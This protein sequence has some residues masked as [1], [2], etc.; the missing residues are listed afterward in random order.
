MVSSMARTLTNDQAM[1][2]LSIVSL[3]QILGILIT[4]G[5]LGLSHAMVNGGRWR[6][7]CWWVGIG[8]SLG[9]IALL[10]I[11][12]STIRVRGPNWSERII[13]F[14]FIGNTVALALGMART[15]GASSSVFSQTI[16][17]QLS[18]MLLLELQKERLTSSKTQAYWWYALIA[19]AFWVAAELI[20]GSRFGIVASKDG[21]YEVWR[22]VASAVLFVVG[23]IFTVITYKFPQSIVDFLKSYVPILNAEQQTPSQ[24]A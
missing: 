2:R 3:I 6:I 17:I 1:D 12:H 19:I 13:Q 4:L 8:T 10:L 11:A 21:D 24:K 7:F 14:V 18:G 9:T 22:R 23:T 16:P 20:G 5:L 15:G